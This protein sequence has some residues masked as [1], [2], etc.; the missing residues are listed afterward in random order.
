MTSLFACHYAFESEA[1]VRCLLR[2]VSARL[3]PGG[4]FFGTIPNAEKIIE[5]CSTSNNKTWTSE[6]FSVTFTE[7]E[8]T[9]LK[10]N[11]N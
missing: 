10:L 1:R 11:T 4:L 2:N 7:T 9:K 8:W 3:C 5:K 6:F